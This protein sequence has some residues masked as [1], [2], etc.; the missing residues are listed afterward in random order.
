MTEDRP[1]WFEPPNDQQELPDP[2]VASQSTTAGQTWFD[3]IEP[4]PTPPGGD[5]GWTDGI[6]G[7]TG[8]E[9]EES[10]PADETQ[11][12][13]LSEPEASSGLEAA[14]DGHSQPE[15]PGV[16]GTGQHSDRPAEG[17]PAESPASGEEPSQSPATASDADPGTVAE[18]GPEEPSHPEEAAVTEDDDLTEV[19][20]EPPVEG[21]EQPSEAE[22]PVEEATHGD[23]EGPVESDVEKVGA[24]EVPDDEAG[25]SVGD[26]SPYDPADREG[27]I[28]GTTEPTEETARAGEGDSV[29]SEATSPGIEAGSSG[30]T[31]EDIPDDVSETMDGWPNT[32]EDSDETAAASGSVPDPEP[33][34]VSEPESDDP[35]LSYRT[36]IDKIKSVFSRE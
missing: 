20:E 35:G 14:H 34:A 17:K 7:E 21:Q 16:D 19:E 9:E 26:E 12:V 30:E 22:P 25:L 33:V 23:E 28:K 18:T 5:Q 6:P 10:T 32:E 27:L 15:A 1:T 3:E 36:V 13:E 29:S 4:S 11:E 8:R 24:T 2:D 31:V